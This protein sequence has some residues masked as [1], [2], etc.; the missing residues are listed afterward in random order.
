MTE[1]I[2]Q[3]I[4]EFLAG[5]VPVNLSEAET[6]AYPFAVY[7]YT[8]EPLRTKDGVAKYSAEVRLR[9]VSKDADQAIQK[10]DAAAQAI[11]AGAAATAGS[12]VMRVM[13][14]STTCVDGIWTVE[15]MINTNQYR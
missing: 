4:T 6:D 12:Y 13:S 15:M 5:V 7:D 9:V 10:A 11:H 8:A 3:K 2:G 14:S 1:N